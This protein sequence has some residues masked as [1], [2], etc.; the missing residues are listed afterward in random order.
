MG[1]LHF[2]GESGMLECDYC[3]SKFSPQ[4][5]EQLYNERAQQEG[6]N[7]A[8]VAAQTATSEN[9]PANEADAHTGAA[10]W[11]ET[12]RGS[13]RAYICESCGAELMTDETTAVT[14]CPYCGN[15]TVLP[16]QLENALRPECVIPFR[17]SK[18]QA[19]EALKAYY[20]GK[21]FLPDGFADENHLQKIQG[22]YV[23]FWLFDADAQGSAVFNAT[24]TTAW[25][26]S[27]NNYVKTDYYKAS[28]EGSVSFSLVPVDASS[29][30]PDAHMYAIEPFDYTDLQ[31]FSMGYLPGYLTDRYDEDADF[32][33]NRAEVRIEQTTS[34]LLAET[35]VGYESVTTESCNVTPTWGE[36]AYAL[37][38]VWMLH[39]KYNDED[40][41]FAMNGQTGKLIGNLPVDKKKVVLHFLI[42]FAPIAAPL[43]ALIFVFLAR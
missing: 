37:L 36:T 21:K 16:G 7:A 31:P 2:A 32:C 3:G 35:V 33:R 8:S 22:V 25:S 1:P 19:I 14:N 20:K 9:S 10:G 4:E 6:G 43:I 5:I 23:P 30:M 26:D 12:E 11:D 17:L 41:L 39:T 29:K 38:P 24:R 15:P 42:L 28:R 34:D 27:K 40:L 13:L 18:Q